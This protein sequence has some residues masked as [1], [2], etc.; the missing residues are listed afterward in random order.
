VSCIAP[1]SLHR[2]EGNRS[3]H[4][5]ASKP[6][7]FWGSDDAST[8]DRVE[9]FRALARRNLLQKGRGPAGLMRLLA[10]CSMAADRQILFEA[11]DRRPRTGVSALRGPHGVT[12]PT[13]RRVTEQEQEQEQEAEGDKWL[14]AR[15]GL[16]ERRYAAF[17]SIQ[18]R[19]PWPNSDSTPQRPPMRSTARATMARPMPVPSC[20]ATSP[21]RSNKPN[22]FSW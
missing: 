16:P 15:A 18:K 3:C 7:P 20:R 5:P 14:A 6:R 19:A 9:H 12:G 21:T 22:T 2:G 10:V 4:S 1:C 17:S 11:V 13:L 8:R